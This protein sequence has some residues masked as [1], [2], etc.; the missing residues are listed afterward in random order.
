MRLAQ[1]LKLKGIL[2]DGQLESAIT[3]LINLENLP[4]PGQDRILQPPGAASAHEPDMPPILGP[5]D[6]H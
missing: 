4:S 1:L 6:L 3:G 2:A 5:D